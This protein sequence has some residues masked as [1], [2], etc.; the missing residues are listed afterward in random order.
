MKIDFKKILASILQKLDD[1]GI[2]SAVVAALEGAKLIDNSDDKWIDNT[3]G[4][5]IEKSSGDYIPKEKVNE[6]NEK[7]RTAME[8][9][10]TE[11]DTLQKKVENGAI[12][13]DDLANL[14]KKHKSE[15]DELKATNKN[16]EIETAVRIALMGANLKKSSYV[17]MFL[18]KI[19]LSA[20]HKLQDGTFTGID[21]QVTKLK[22]SEDF[23]DWFGETT[24]NGDPPEGTDGHTQDGDVHK[25]DGKSWQD[26]TLTDKSRLKLNNK[27]LFD[28]MKPS[29]K[30]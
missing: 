20:V 14:R 25:W 21:E 18:P 17:D 10:D 9:R 1:A 26:L 27:T 23:K 12:S 7:H 8:K 19:E 28:K 22:E 11:M 29:E 24:L 2:T 30:K 3:D 5:W 16:L 15:T 4:K 6:I 13:A